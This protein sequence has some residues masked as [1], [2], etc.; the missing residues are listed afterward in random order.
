VC[1]HV[2]FYII[3][4]AWRRLCM[5]DAVWLQAGAQEVRVA[6]DQR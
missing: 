1:V 3:P 2:R 6:E 4:T 5:I